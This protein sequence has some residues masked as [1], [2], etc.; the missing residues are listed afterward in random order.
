M[1]MQDDPNQP[2]ESFFDAVRHRLTLR[3]LGSLAVS[4]TIVAAAAVLAAALSRVVF[5]YAAE[6]WWY[7]AAGAG[8]IFATLVAWLVTLPSAEASAREADEAFGLHDALV[9]WLHFGEAGKRGGFYDLQAK[10]SAQSVAPLDSRQVEVRPPRNR[11]L[12][13][14][15]LAVVA[16]GLGFMQPSEAVQQRLAQEEFT[17]IESQRINQQLEELV[18]ELDEQV[19]GEER[20]LIDPDKLREQIEAL[21]ETADPKLALRQYAKLEQKLQQ[22]LNKLNQRRDEQ[23]AARAAKELDKSAETR[24]LAKPLDAKQ[25][26]QAAKEL[27]NMQPSKTAKLS[28]QQ[29]QAARLRA[30]SQRMAAAARSR[31]SSSA[32]S[33]EGSPAGKSGASAKGSGSR[34]EG[35]ASGA[36]GQGGEGD[37]SGELA[38]AMLDLDAAVADLEAALREACDQ[39]KRDGQCNSKCLGKLS[40][41]QS[42][43]NGACNSLS[44][45]L[46]KMAIKKKAQCRLA[47]LCK[48]CSQ[49]QGGLCQSPSSKNGRGVGASS[50]DSRRDPS[51][52]ALAAGPTERLTGIKNAGPSQ[53]TT[54]SADDGSGVST[55]VAQ[56]KEREFRRSVESYVSRE[57]VPPA[58]RRGVKRYFE[59]I[60]QIETDPPSEAGL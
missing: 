33:S 17:L 2:I 39:E 10:Q 37:D 14:L 54:E 20:E 48:S 25:Y 50:V 40:Q 22:Q 31:R 6:P 5:G 11:L 4:A 46:S 15:A 16:G 8:A 59:S 45:C 47:S 13:A 27:Q 7:A 60:H 44:K 12:L 53:K 9:S 42:K 3:R 18:K 43:C 49:C 21:E 32:N 1:S 28:E 34:G 23:L 41:C 24:K 35:Q 19:E 58:V 56:S 30:A 55:R 52:E 29:K 38:N 57:D 26:D 36:A 51:D